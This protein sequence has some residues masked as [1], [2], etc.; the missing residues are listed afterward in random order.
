MQDNNRDTETARTDEHY[1]TE[2]WAARGLPPPLDLDSADYLTKRIHEV[3]ERHLPKNNGDLELLEIGCASSRWLP[4]FARHYGFRIC[5]IDYSD[6]GCDVARQILNRDGVPGTVIHGDAFN[7]SPDL[8]N[9]FDVVVSMGLVEHFRDTS[10]CVRSFSRFVKPGGV[11]IT[12]VPNMVGWVGAAQKAL[13]RRAYDGHEPLDLERLETGHREAGLIGIDAG[14]IGILDFHIVH[15][16]VPDGSKEGF[17]AGLLTHKILM[18]LS[19]I[20]WALDSVVKLPATRLTA[21]GFYCVAKRP[22]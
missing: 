19:R 2:K 17:S 15:R 18:R 1:W 5:G 14:P 3:F 21:A 13:N 22:I 9:R 11:L 4:Y 8:E 10:A 12:T 20:T 16:D 7:P 6:V